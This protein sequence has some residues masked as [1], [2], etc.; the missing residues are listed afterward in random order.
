[1]Y[2]KYYG[3]ENQELCTHEDY[4][5]SSNKVKIDWSDD[6]SLENWVSRF[7]L[8]CADSHIIGLLGTMFFAGTTIFGVLIT[9][10]GDIYGRM[11][12]TRISSLFSVA[13]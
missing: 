11:W 2:P 1:M 6:W 12:I 10:M 4:C 9:R 3:C 7:N 13:V 5:Q 8:A